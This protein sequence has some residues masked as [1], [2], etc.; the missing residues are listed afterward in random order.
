MDAIDKTFVAE[1][2]TKLQAVDIP[3]HRAQG[4]AQR[5]NHANT[6]IR[7]LADRLPMSTEPSTFVAM[8]QQLRSDAA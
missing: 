6:V 3:G 5:A 4:L 2:V 7:T 8:L 1:V